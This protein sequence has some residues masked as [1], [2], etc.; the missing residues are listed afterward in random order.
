M[1]I[2]YKKLK[3]EE[4]NDNIL[5]GFD[6]YQVIDRVKYLE[7]GQIL[8]KSIHFVEVWDDDKL[9]EVA[10]ECRDVLENGGVFLIAKDGETVAGFATVESEIFFDEY[11]NLKIIQVSNPYRNKGIGTV[12]FQ[13]IES[14]AKVLGA[15]K[16]YI[17][18]HSSVASQMFYKNRGCVLT[19]KLHPELYELEPYDIHLEKELS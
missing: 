13:M 4:V 3:L 8:E 10:R 5:S 12:L 11:L 15:K 7:N 14:E 1:S 18:G 19:K 2:T 9:K 6:R 17:S 16:L